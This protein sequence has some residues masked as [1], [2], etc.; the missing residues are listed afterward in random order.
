MF[1]TKTAVNYRNH[2]EACSQVRDLV[3]RLVRMTRT[4]YA[5]VAGMAAVHHY[6][7]HRN[8]HKSSAA[9]SAAT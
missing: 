8:L 1:E 3:T 4:S 6:A 7:L 9:N 2:A 5:W